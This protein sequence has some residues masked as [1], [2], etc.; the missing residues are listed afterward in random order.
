MNIFSLQ[1]YCK[2]NLYKPFISVYN[3][4][5]VSEDGRDYHKII[6]CIWLIQLYEKNGEKDLIRIAF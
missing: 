6:S 2:L 5:R 3:F 4:V 1:V